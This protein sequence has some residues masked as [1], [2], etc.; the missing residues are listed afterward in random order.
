MIW[1]CIVIFIIAFGFIAIS[2][3]KSNVKK[4]KEAGERLDKALEALP[5]FKSTKKITG[6]NYEYLFAVD[7]NSKKIAIVRSLLVKKIIPFNQIYGVEISEDNTI[8]QQK[9][10]L[11][12]IGGAMIGGAIAGG[13]GAIVGGLSG[14]V[15]QNKKVSKVKVV[16]KLRDINQPTYIINCF[17]CET[18]TVD[19]SPVKPSS[20]QWAIYKRGLGHAQQIADTI[21]A[22][23]DI[24]DRENKND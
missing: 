9:S 18:M 4:L 14:D 21:S 8:I 2:I 3:G 13:A 10:S 12:T 11:R 6:I 15:T 17:N 5:D 19:K 22:I 1:I 23:I 16:I 24:T 20:S 7:E